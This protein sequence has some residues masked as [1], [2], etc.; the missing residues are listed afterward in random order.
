MSSILSRLA[1]AAVCSHLR[2]FPIERGKCRLLRWASAFLVVRLQPGV[3]VRITDPDN[4][5][6]AGLARRG[7]LEQQDLEVFLS[8]L[9]PGM[10]VLDVGAN[11]GMYSL[12]I[13][14]AVG[15]AGRVH[16]FEPTPR[17]ATNLRR[18]VEIN[19][20]SN[21]EVRQMAVGASNGAAT[22]YVGPESDRNSI[23]AKSASA[24]EVN[25]TVVTLDDYIRSHEIQTV[26][27]VKLDIEGGE[28]DAVRGSKRL[29]SGDAA[30]LVMFEINPQALAEAGSSATELRAVLASYGYTCHVLHSYG[31]GEYAN[32]F[33]IKPRHHE[34][35]PE[36][37]TLKMTPIT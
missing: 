12:L 10:T 27:M 1:S 20:L 6:E 9:R 26:D 15:P 24:T 23:V 29:L 14:R 34:R 18:N 33:A 13:A 25:V 31:G 36:L 11:V 7:L 28:V 5:I 22:L 16:A 19:K 37:H 30:P 35:F 3:Y 2:H 17:V 32:A 21:V 4:P 8:M